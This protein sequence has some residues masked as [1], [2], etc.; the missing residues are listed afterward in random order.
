MS[1][2]DSDDDLDDLRAEEEDSEL[3]SMGLPVLPVVGLIS[4]LMS[5]PA[6]QAVSLKSGEL[7]F[8]SVGETAFAVPPQGVPASSDTTS[9]RT[10]DRAVPVQASRSSHPLPRASIELDFSLD[11]PLP[12]QSPVAAARQPTAVPNRATTAVSTAPSATDLDLLFQGGSFSLVAKAVG[13][14]EGTRTPDGGRT[15]AYYGHRDPGNGVWNL[16][17]FSY[18][19]GADSPA[20]ADVK[21]LRRL[22]GQARRLRQQAERLGVQMSLLEELNGIDL[23]NQSPR[24]ALSRG[25]YVERLQ[26]AH[27][28]GLQGMDAVIWARTRSFLNPDTGQW[29]A[30][31]LGNREDSIKADQER[32]L[33][34]IQQAITYHQL[35]TQSQAGAC[36]FCSD[37]F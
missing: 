1:G 5:T 21:Q 24:A 9:A 29:N 7:D 28:Q 36:H 33:Q 34:A 37:A 10:A 6:V 19:H 8:N 31:G 25:G 11:S 26:E 3:R 35:Q 17:S 18:Q 30:P 2:P 15:W 20:E 4:L 32:R 23:A 14:A 12:Q 27:Q 22:T 16:G 13:A